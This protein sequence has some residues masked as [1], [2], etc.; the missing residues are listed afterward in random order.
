MC[1]SQNKE[2]GMYHNLGN[3]C[4]KIKKTIFSMY[5]N[6]KVSRINICIFKRRAQ[7]R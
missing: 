1:E 5:Y 4:I 6:Q 2:F 3:T 7:Q